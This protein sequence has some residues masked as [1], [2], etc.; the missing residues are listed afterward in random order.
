M[1]KFGC[2]TNGCD[3]FYDEETGDPD[4]DLAARPWS[5]VGDHFCCPFCG[6]GK[7]DFVLEK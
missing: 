6:Q 5:E 3:Y 4:F 2:S 1:S 7:D